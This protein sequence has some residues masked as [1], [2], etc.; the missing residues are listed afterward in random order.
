MTLVAP[1]SGPAS[2]R[3]N[4][5]Q[6]WQR[7]SRP[8]AHS[9]KGLQRTVTKDCTDTSGPESTVALGCEQAVAG[10]KALGGRQKGPP[11]R[12]WVPG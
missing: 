1:P 9:D 11:Q 8:A 5:W 4:R 3:S 2:L 12:L 10:R 6:G 7:W